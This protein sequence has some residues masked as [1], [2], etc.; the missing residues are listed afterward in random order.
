MS[1]NVAS[2]SHSVTISGSGWR[3]LFRSESY[4][5]IDLGT[6]FQ[7]EDLIQHNATYNYAH[8][9]ASPF[10][11]AEVVVADTDL[12]WVC[13]GPPSYWRIS[14]AVYHM[15][16]SRRAWAVAPVPELFLML[17]LNTV[18]TSSTA[19]CAGAYSFSSRIRWKMTSTITFLSGLNVSLGIFTSAIN[20]PWAE[21][22]GPNW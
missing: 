8:E 22:D 11:Q 7:H 9:A 21:I 19:S 13:F 2:V 15:I 10:G 16:M 6:S 12:S 5:L 20:P 3:T 17:G 18:P 14:S 1:Q 4:H